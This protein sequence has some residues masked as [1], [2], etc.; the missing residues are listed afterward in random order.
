MTTPEL[1]NLLK[2]IALVRS[3]SRLFMKRH[4][5]IQREIFDSLIPSDADEL[6]AEIEGVLSQHRIHV[7]ELINAF[8]EFAIG[9]AVI[10][11]LKE[12]KGVKIGEEQIDEILDGEVQST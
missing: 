12:I 11:R 3:K 9:V 4:L 6:G 2:Q 8:D 5:E 7:N 1:F 10:E